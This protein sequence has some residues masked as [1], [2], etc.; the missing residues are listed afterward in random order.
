MKLR[1]TRKQLA[2]LESEAKKAFP[3]EA[4]AL[5]FGKLAEKEA[6]VERIAVAPNTMRSTTRFE[7]DPKAFYDAFTAASQDGLTFLG[8]YH[9]HPAPATPSNVDLR[10]M[11]LWGDALWLIFSLTENRF[12]AFRMR[13]GRAQALILES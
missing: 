2:C 8:F 4:C 13:K 6:T 3:I 10:F 12:A 1:V 9:S 5:M 11:R 7:I